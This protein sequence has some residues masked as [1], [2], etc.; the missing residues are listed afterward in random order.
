MPKSGSLKAAGKRQE[1]ATFLRRSVFN[2]ALQFFTC[3]SAAF[4]KNDIRTAEKRM[5]QCNFT[6]AQHSENCSTDSVFACGMLQGWGL[7]GWG[8]DLMSFGECALVPREHANV[9]SFRF[10]YRET[11]EC[12]LVPVFVPGEHPPNPPFWK[13]TLLSTPKEVAWQ[14]PPAKRPKTWH[15]I[16]CTFENARSGLAFPF[17]RHTCGNVGL[18]L[19]W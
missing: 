15:R 18:G 16:S 6:A 11:S 2:V 12:T 17:G 8:M 10:R 1:S 19:L 7:E 5:L 4:G 14:H 3:C 13:T 9:P